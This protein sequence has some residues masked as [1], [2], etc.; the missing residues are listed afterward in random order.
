MVDPVDVDTSAYIVG[1]SST[2]FVPHIIWILVPVHSN[3]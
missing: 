2:D 1:V 3:S